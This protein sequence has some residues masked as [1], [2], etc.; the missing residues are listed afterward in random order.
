MR[1]YYDFAVRYGDL[2]FARDAV[3]VTKTH[4]GGVNEEIKVDALVPVEVTPTPGALWV[5]AIRVGGGL[6][7]SLI[8][9][10]PERD[11]LWDSPKLGSSLLSGVRIHLERR[12][13]KAPR[14]FFA[15][16][17][18]S[19][20]L[21]PLEPEPRGRDDIVAV[22]AFRTWALVWVPGDPE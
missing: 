15:D 17:E 16:P 4:L 6:L 8:D 11:T 22:P 1:S 2:L 3:D 5:R 18:L 21:Q 19:P 13:G 10:S 14:F 12:R 7:L 20:R 9:L